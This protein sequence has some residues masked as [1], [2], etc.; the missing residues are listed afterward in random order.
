MSRLSK[1]PIQLPE[2]VSVTVGEGRALVKG[3]KG[4]QEVPILPM[5]EV[6]VTEEGVTVRTKGERK[7][8]KMNRGTTWSLIRNAVE[9][10]TKGFTKALEIQGVGYR[11]TLEGKT[12]VL[13]LG[14]SHPIRYTPPDGISLEVEKNIVRVHGSNKQEVG[15]VAAAIRAFRKPEPYKGTGVRYQGEIVRRKAGKKAVTSS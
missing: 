15:A 6:A 5:V 13:L 1:K 2:G 3:P 7:R 4:T 11:A 9:G 10:V 14:Y 8:E 12:L